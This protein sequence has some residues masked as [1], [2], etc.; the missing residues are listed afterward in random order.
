MFSLHSGPKTTTMMIVGW[1][2]LWLSNVLGKSWV[3]F[4][5]LLKATNTKRAKKALEYFIHVL[6]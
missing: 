2:V 5:Q 4:G 3:N 1:Q 6:I